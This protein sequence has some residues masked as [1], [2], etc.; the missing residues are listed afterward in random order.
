[1]RILVYSDAPSVCTGFGS[2]TRN[3]FG[4]LIDRGVLTPDDVSFFGVN[5]TGDF[6]P[7]QHK[8]HQWP[9]ALGMGNDRDPYGRNRFCQMTLNNTWP[10]D[11]L[12]VLQDHFTV[13][14]FLPGL[15]KQL[16]EQIPQGRPPFKVIYYIPI[17]GTYLRPD[18][19]QWIPEYVD[20]PVAYMHW[21]AKLLTGMVPALH[22]K[23]RVIYHGT[24]PE[25][26]FP[27]DAE[28]R[29][30]F[31]RNVLKVADDQPLVI[32]VNRNQPR[33]DP[34][35]VL[36]VF[37]RVH[38]KYPNAVLYMHMN[39]ADSMGYNLDTVRQQLRLPQASVRFPANFCEGIGVPLETV[40]L[41]YNAADVF[42]TTARGEGFGLTISECMSAGTPI[43]SPNHTSFAELLAQQRGALALPMP[44][45]EVMIADNDQFRPVA[46][47]RA[48]ADKVC[49]AIEHRDH[50]RG[51]AR[52]AVEWART[53]SW[54]DAIAPQ[55]EQVFREA[56]AS[57]QPAA[58]VQ[59]PTQTVARGYTFTAQGLGATA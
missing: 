32:S 18:W 2:V 50:A 36:Q 5:Y 45:K 47:V 20:Y 6:F 54:R 21:S 1:M 58:Q 17:D 42:V 51:Q 4:P 28:T 16:R 27:V 38:Q 15:V 10:F 13:A 56:Y 30:Q 7:D 31:R 33:K 26:F 19:V 3:I 12:F 14:P 55:W 22:G 9:A 29:L 34:V 49:W 46:D 11:L 40:N 39:V 24:N 52:K 23:L 25:T 8:F 41:I 57:L 37:E 48:M 59:T 44:D 53:I 35:R 43:V